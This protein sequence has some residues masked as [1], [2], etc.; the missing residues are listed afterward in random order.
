[1]LTIN[2]PIST[3]YTSKPDELNGTITDSESSVDKCWHNATGVN[4]TPSDCSSGIFKFIG[5]QGSVIEGTNLWYVY[6]ND[7]NGNVGEDSVSFDVDLPPTTT[8]IEPLNGATVDLI[9]NFS[10]SSSDTQ[11]IDSQWYSYDSGT[12]TTY[13]T[14]PTQL[15]GVKG[16]HSI[17]AYANDTYGSISSDSVVFTVLGAT[18]VNDTVSNISTTTSIKDCR[19]KSFGIYNPKL[20]QINEV[21]CIK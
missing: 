11:G 4:S 18:D 7:S 5:L 2:Y 6:G 21:N 16:S 1:M 15:T 8:I 14:T 19:I 12:N 10:M 17:T 20:P 3:T 13:S 9:F